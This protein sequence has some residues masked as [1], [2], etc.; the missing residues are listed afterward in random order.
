MPNSDRKDPHH[1][2]MRNE[3][4][5]ERKERKHKENENLDQSLEETFPGSD[6]ISP[7]V[8]AKVPADD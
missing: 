8:P 5:R 4:P 3:T 7:F 2:P 1:A 6:P